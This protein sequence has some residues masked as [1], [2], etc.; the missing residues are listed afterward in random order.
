MVK[1]KDMLIWSLK[2]KSTNKWRFIKPVLIPE[3]PMCL[4]K[5]ISEILRHLSIHPI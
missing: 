3:L 2:Q 4:A 5:T 1:S